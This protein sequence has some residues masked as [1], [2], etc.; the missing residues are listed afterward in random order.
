MLKFRLLVLIA[1]SILVLSPSPTLCATP[2]QM[3]P[4]LLAV[5]DAPVPFR[6]SDGLT[7][8]VYELSV[9]NFSSGNTEV[10]K[11]EVLGDGVVLQTLDAA[12]VA[13]RLQPVGSRQSV[14]T[15]ARSAQALLFLSIALPPGAAVPQNLTH[16]VE[17]HYSAAPPA[18]QLFTVTGGAVRVD[19]QPVATFGPPLAGDNYISAD[20]CCDAIRHTRAA[21]PINGRVV[22]AQRFAVDWEQLNAAHQVYS[23]P[24]EKLESYT[25]FGK[26]ALAVADAAVALIVKGLGEQTPGKYPVDISPEDADGNAVILDLGQHRYAL[27]AHLQSDSIHLKPGDKVKRGEVIGLVGNSG[28]SLAPHLH[29]HVMDSELS[30]ASNGLPYEIDQFT[31]TANSPGT[32]AFD[33]VEASGKPLAISPITPPHVVKDALPLDQLIVSFAPPNTPH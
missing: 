21:L 23:G 28:N 9:T 14:S 4:L 16:R 32:A 33:E 10:R 25:I 20:S 3:T 11:V 26:P 31:V 22:V 29:F 27:Y 17:A 13:S 2:Q 24:R 19:R 5:P 30:L 6:G 18:H 15:L 12:S 1:C 8:L 7:H